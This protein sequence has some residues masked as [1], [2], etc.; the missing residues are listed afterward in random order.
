[1]FS[2]CSELTPCAPIPDG[3]MAQFMQRWQTPVDTDYNDYNDYRDNDLDLGQQTL[4]NTSRHQQT[5][6]GTSRQ[7]VTWT[8]FAILAMFIQTPSV[9]FPVSFYWQI[10]FLFSIL[11][12]QYFVH[13]CMSC[14]RLYLYYSVVTGLVSIHQLSVEETQQHTL[15]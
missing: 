6:V 12:I 9:G 3:R 10:I 1:M 2:M 7:T 4:V 14:M 5:L 13:Q 15:E 8:A 11:F